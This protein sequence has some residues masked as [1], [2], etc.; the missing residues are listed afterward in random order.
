MHKESPLVP[1]AI[2]CDNKKGDRRSEVTTAE[3]EQ[4]TTTEE[5][6]SY[7]AIFCAISSLF[8][9][10]RESQER[11]EEGSTRER[12][13]R[14]PRRDQL[15]PKRSERGKSNESSVQREFKKSSVQRE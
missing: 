6:T 10:F 9:V 1:R 7:A 4:V 8:V 5:A 13:N 11:V 2:E 12:A 3:T 14:E 15:C